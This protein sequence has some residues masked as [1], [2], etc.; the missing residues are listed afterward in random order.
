MDPSRP[1]LEAI[2]HRLQALEAENAALRKLLGVPDESSFGNRVAEE[3]HLAPT[4]SAVRVADASPAAT[5][6]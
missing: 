2:V 5:M 6:P 3:V 1:D 4:F